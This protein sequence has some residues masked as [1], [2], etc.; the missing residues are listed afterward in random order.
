[1]QGIELPQVSEVICHCNKVVT[2]FNHSYVAQRELE[3]KQAQLEL[4][5]KKLI[6]S[7]PTRWNSSYKMLERLL[8]QRAAVSAGLLSSSKSSD[9]ALMLT[10][11]EINRM[12]CIVKVLNP[13]GHAMTLL[14][15][16]KTP[17]LSIVQAVLEL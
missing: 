8:E 6:Q 2:H 17:S 16:E 13:L 4:P 14:C 12:E 5:Q 3:T 10:S 1:M 7:M 11:D 15:E 9:R